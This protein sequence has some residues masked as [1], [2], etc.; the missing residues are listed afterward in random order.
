MGYIYI[1]IPYYEWKHLGTDKN[2]KMSYLKN[3]LQMQEKNKQGYFLSNY[4]KR[5]Y[6]YI[7]I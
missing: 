7:C 4:P 5:Q 6:E 3:K 2:V 1:D